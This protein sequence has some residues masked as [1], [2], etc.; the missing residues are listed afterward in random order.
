ME[1]EFVAS[2]AATEQIIDLGIP[3]RYLGVPIKQNL[4]YLE[5]TGQ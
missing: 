4:T 1:T 3:F 5:T 2:K